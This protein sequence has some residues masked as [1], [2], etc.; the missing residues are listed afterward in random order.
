MPTPR[1]LE[2]THGGRELANSVREAL[3]QLHRA[4]DQQ[5]NFD[6]ATSERTFRIHTSIYLVRCLLPRVCAR[7]RAEAPRVGLIV[8]RPALEF[9][10]SS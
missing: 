4:V 10:S 6:P 3:Q 5:L 9:V 1:G 2:P 8:D 7:I